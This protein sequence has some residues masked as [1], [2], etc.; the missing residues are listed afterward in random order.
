MCAVQHR[1]L[2]FTSALGFVYGMSATMRRCEGERQ[3]AV[4]TPSEPDW[5]SKLM[6]RLAEAQP[7]PTLPLSALAGKELFHYTTADGLKG[8]IEQN[9]LWATGASYLNDASEVDYGCALLEE[10]FTDWENANKDNTDALGVQVLTALQGDF[11]DPQSKL[12][13]TTG[14]YVAC[15]C[16]TDN[17][18]SQWRA[19]GQTGGYSVGF[20]MLGSGLRALGVSGLSLLKPEN[21]DFRI[22]LVRVIYDRKKQSER[23]HRILTD[24][25]PILDEPGIRAE[26]ETE[27]Q[28]GLAKAFYIAMVIIGHLLLEEIVAFKNEAFAEEQEWRIVVRPRIAARKY[29]GPKDQNDSEWLHLRATR[30]L[31]IPYTRI[32][33]SI[34]DGMLPI[35]SVRFG[36]SLDKVRAENSLRMLLSLNGY[37]HIKKIHGSGIPVLL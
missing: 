15:F 18:L 32:V 7:Q 17:L 21:P 8:I 10:V 9:C 13:R 14:I 22:N 12:E 3:E 36:P 20:S 11:K 23:L 33:P 31:M 2:I 28:K 24:T 16:E 25:L 27:G 30:G 19:Y 6:N 29:V 37:G 5:Q 26:A 1:C 35:T 34:P 4:T